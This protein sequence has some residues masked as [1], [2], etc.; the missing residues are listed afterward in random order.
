MFV[1]HDQEEATVMSDRIVVMNAGR[2]EQI[3]RPQEVYHAPKTRFVAGFFGENNLVDGNVRS[4]KAVATPIGVLRVES[5]LAP[6][7]AVTAAIRPETIRLNGVRRPGDLVFQADVRD[8]V[9]LGP[10]TQVLL[11]PD[12]LAGGTITARIAGDQPVKIGTTVGIS[13]S[14]EDIAIVPRDAAL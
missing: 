6:G 9:F 8:V 7:A 12:G 4:D 13:V 5:P 14:P 1:T 2:I 10:S 11:R 3:G